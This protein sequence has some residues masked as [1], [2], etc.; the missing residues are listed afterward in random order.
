M[1][2]GFANGNNSNSIT[3][4]GIRE[5]YDNLGEKPKGN[6]APLPIVF[7]PVLDGDQWAIE[8][9]LGV[10][11]IDAVFGEIELSLPFI[12]REHDRSVATLCGYVKTGAGQRSCRLTQS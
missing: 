10:V 5:R 2:Q 8:D 3:T 6:I 9:R 1:F 12:P 11:K 7:T 4:L